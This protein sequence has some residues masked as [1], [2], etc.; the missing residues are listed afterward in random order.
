MLR[1]FFAAEA[2]RGHACIDCNLPDADWAT[3]SYAGYLCVDCAGRHRGLGVHLSFVR[4]TTMDI[5]S[6]EQLRRMQL[7]GSFRFR[8]F[9]QSYPKLLEEPQTSSA[10]LA[11]YSSRA[12]HYY[13]KLLDHQCAGKDAALLEP[14]PSEAEGQRSADD[15]VPAA[16]RDDDEAAV[17]AVEEEIAELEAA[18]ERHRNLKASEGKDSSP[19][20]PKKF[21][22]EEK[23]SGYTAGGVPSSPPPLC[24]GTPQSPPPIESPSRMDHSERILGNALHVNMGDAFPGGDATPGG[25][26]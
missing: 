6:P 18:Y 9:L 7:G 25:G 21:E 12:L 26:I 10:L 24:K 1:V 20:L 11:R 19:N 13:R 17:G 15:T 8:E 14:M 22:K 4:S 2:S 16:G 23:T 5:W 3:V